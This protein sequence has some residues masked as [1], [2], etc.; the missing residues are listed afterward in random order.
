VTG[1]VLRPGLCKRCLR[2]LLD[3]PAGAFGRDGDLPVPVPGLCTRCGLCVSRCPKGA[4]ELPG[5]PAGS[6]I[7]TPGDPS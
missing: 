3:C 4:L 1:P 5:G 7:T 6:P 2:C